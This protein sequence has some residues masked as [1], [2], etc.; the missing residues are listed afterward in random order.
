[1]SGRKPPQITDTKLLC[2]K[3]LKRV[4][5]K[6]VSKRRNKA[7]FE[8]SL[9]RKFTEKKLGEVFWVKMELTKN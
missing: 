7:C 2:K 3:A 9:P 1:M 8:F 4:H 6:S 5:E